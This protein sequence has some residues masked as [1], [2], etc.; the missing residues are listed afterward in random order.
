[1]AQVS[2]MVDSAA[3]G[4]GNRASEVRRAIPSHWSGPAARGY[5]S[6]TELIERRMLALAA[7]FRSAAE[8]LRAH[9][10]ELATMKQALTAGV[11]AI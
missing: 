11:R 4:L 7:A 6:D 1:M 5:L 8:A 9:E 3:W 10:G 2:A